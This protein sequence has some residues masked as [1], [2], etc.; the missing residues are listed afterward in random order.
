M[1]AN[2]KNDILILKDSVNKLISSN[3]HSGVFDKEEFDVAIGNQYYRHIDF[4][5]LQ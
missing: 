2:K 4:S 5:L 1:L 3:V